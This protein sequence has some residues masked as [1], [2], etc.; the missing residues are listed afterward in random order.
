MPRTPLFAY[1]TRRRSLGPKWATPSRVSIVPV[2]LV[3]HL[4]GYFRLERELVVR[5]VPKDKRR[6]DHR[7]FPPEDLSAGALLSI[8]KDRLSSRRQRR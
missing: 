4:S 7:A 1:A 8:A 6:G 3:A 5:D 2:N